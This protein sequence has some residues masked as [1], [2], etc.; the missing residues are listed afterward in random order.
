[1]SANGPAGRAAGD[2]GGGGLSPAQ[3]EA[4]VLV[5]QGLPK[6][7][8]ARRVGVA[9]GTV[10]RWANAI[11]AFRQA[12]EDRIKAK[13]LSLAEEVATS[14]ERVGDLL[15]VA[16]KTLQE[17]FGATYFAVLPRG[18]LEA[19]EVR[20]L[21]AWAIRLQAVRL[22]YQVAG[23]LVQRIEHAGEVRLIER[24]TDEELDE[25]YDRLRR[26]WEPNPN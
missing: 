17:A 24:M 22:A 10:S 12:V 26:A 8:V 4:V 13:E 20:E 14:R 11:P 2:G 25:A 23:M 7:E 1:M 21:P 19:P 16:D 6:S 18:E 9:R 3:R 15:E 5:A